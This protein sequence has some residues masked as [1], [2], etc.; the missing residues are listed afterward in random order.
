MM[1]IKTHS[2]ILDRFFMCLQIFLVTKWA[3]FHV[4]LPN[5]GLYMALDCQEDWIQKNS[6]EFRILWISAT[7][8]YS[9]HDQQKVCSLHQQLQRSIT[10]TV[11]I[12][13]KILYSL[14]FI[15]SWNSWGAIFTSCC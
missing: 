2:N 14:K 9:L 8:N 10:A 3:F 12:N 6:L 1:M 7:P 5:R 13:C 15:N 4:Q 11:Y